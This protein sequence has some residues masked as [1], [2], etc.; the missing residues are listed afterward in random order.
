[1]YTDVVDPL[2]QMPQVY[3]KE[4]RG[5]SLYSDKIEVSHGDT[6]LPLEEAGKLIKESKILRDVSYDICK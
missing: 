2:L 3:H 5:I 6:L 4:I 1:M